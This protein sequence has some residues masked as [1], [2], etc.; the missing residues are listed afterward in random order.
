M[1]TDRIVRAHGPA[2]ANVAVIS[3]Y[4]DNKE[5][6]SGEV[7]AGYAQYYIKNIFEDTG[8]RPNDIYY[9]S[10]IKDRITA[11][12]KGT[13]P[14]AHIEKTRDIRPDIKLLVDEIRAIKPN[15]IVP[16]GEVALRV[17]TGN[18]NVRKLAG[19]I[20]R[21]GSGF[22]VSNYIK[23]IPMLHPRD[24][25]KE[26]SQTF[27][28]SVYARRVAKYAHRTDFP[29]QK[30]RT[31]VIRNAT[32]LGEYFDKNKDAKR[33]VTD[34][35]TYFNFI[36]CIGFCCDGELGIS[37]PLL[38]KSITDLEHAMM[39][40]QIAK[41]LWEG[42]FTNQNI[43]FDIGQLENHQF[44]IGGV[45]GDTMLKAGVLYPELDKNLGYL[46]SL[47]TEIP[48]FKDEGKEFNPLVN[49]KL[50]EYNAKDCISTW[51]I[52]E[53][54]DKEMVELGVKH[55][56]V[57]GPAKW[58]HMYRKIED[59]GVRV[60]EEARQSLRKKYTDMSNDY[61][62]AIEAFLGAPFN[63]RSSK[64]C[65]E[66]LYDELKLPV[67]K[68]KRA[69][70]SKTPTAD[71]DALEYLALNKCDEPLWKDL[72]FNLIVIR[73][74]EKI[75]Q[76]IDSVVHPDG[77]MRTRYKISGTESGRTSTSQ[78]D[79]YYYYLEKDK[80][81]RSKYG[82]SIQ[83]FPKHGYELITGEEIGDDLRKMFIP[84]PGYQY[85][86]WDQK[87]AEAVVVGALARDFDM[88]NVIETGD[89]HKWTAAL[90]LGKLQT[91]ITKR[92]RQV[93]GKKTRHGGHYDETFKTLA[94]QAK[95]SERE[96][97]VALLKFHAAAP[98]IRGVFQTEIARV[99]NKDRCMITPHG[100]RRDFLGRL[101]SNT[102]REAYS[103]IPQAVVSDNQKFGMLKIQEAVDD[104]WFLME[105]HDGTLAEI[106]IGSED[107]VRETVRDIMEQPTKF[108][109]GTFKRDPVIIRCEFALSKGSWNDMEEMK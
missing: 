71:A 89:L 39:Y 79:D 26:Y 64:A 2:N 77:R 53:A 74:L 98:N 16:L 43:G 102:M 70:G 99:V 100:R 13:N 85:F 21:V 61:Q 17:V 24:L 72:L 7:L 8:V 60:D 20:L 58:F 96:A 37:V 52:D 38:E 93:Q 33:K 94:A 6:L 9:T 76:Y 31:E 22:A 51:Q 1:P 62:N 106:P 59:R 103:Y 101:D 41:F 19:S 47:Y 91:E 14:L 73:K 109:E 32:R 63:P 34:V 107:K 88:L 44:Y 95:I 81:K 50:Y 36:T 35:E 46:N 28:C 104:I 3:D 48:Y 49:D 18:D 45:G 65:C 84:S 27:N 40:K 29:E 12:P 23:V 10:I 42:T 25:R 5:L 90:V 66:L 57:K 105:A 15:V 86:E 87:Q 80:V 68:K 83:Q 97:K 55:F 78:C 108:E 11:P 69:D 82:F 56:Y 54:Q 75:L 4:P 92:E 30:W 67:Q